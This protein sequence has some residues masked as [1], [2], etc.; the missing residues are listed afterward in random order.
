MNILE[1]TIRFLREN[2]HFTRR[3]EPRTSLPISSARIIAIK[4]Q[5]VVAIGQYMSVMSL[6]RNLRKGDL[7]LIVRAT[8]KD[9]LR[10]FN[11]LFEDQQYVDPS[12]KFSFNSDV[13]N[14]P[15][16]SYFRIFERQNNCHCTLINQILRVQGISGRVCTLNCNISTGRVSCEP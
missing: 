10:L 15:Q 6:R 11:V 2:L 16:S 9:D 4:E 1:T 7:N 12:A 13:S 14:M 8:D 3:R 5:P